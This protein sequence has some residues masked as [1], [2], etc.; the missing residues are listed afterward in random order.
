M[1]MT[2]PLSL[3]LLLLI[4][5]CGG[6]KQSTDDLIKVD[7]TAD[8]P[9]K[10]LSLQDFLDVEYIPLDTS[11]EFTTMAYIQAISD[12]A[13]IVRNRNRSSDG[14]IFVFDR[15]G[16]G[17]RKINR[18][19]PGG[20]EYTFL[21]WVTW[22]EENNEVF[23]NDHRTKKIF[24]Y[25]L[26]GKFKR[27]FPHK[28]DAWY[29]RVYNFDHDHL[30]C[31]DAFGMSDNPSQNIFLI[32]SKQDGSITTEI[33]IPYEKKRPTLVFSK[34]G[35]FIAE[36]DNEKFVPFHDEWILAETSSDTLYRLMPDRRI[37]P[38]IVRTPSIQS[39]D[40]EIFLFPGV[41][42]DRYYFMQ[43]VKK[44]Y[45]FAADTGFPGTDLV[46]DT[47]QKALFRYV[48]YNADFSTKEALNLAKGITPINKEIAFIQ[49]LEAA[50]LV[51]A[52][53]KGQLKGPLKEIAAGLNEES[54][55]VIMVAKNR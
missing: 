33:E 13:L 34:D 8:Y 25:D 15:K 20:E 43:A 1:K 7:V 32:V 31:H 36:V 51:E 26:F 22:D 9:L 38:F 6:N 14:D 18:Q 4:S 24:V 23:V 41:F 42:T 16:K 55:P 46:Y 45:D 29:D 39:M 35:N 27:S 10:E 50:D 3:M 28:E 52:Y 19:G 47:E 48:V 40:Q 44:E 21:L 54:N 2:I 30:I 12:N 17:L 5:G 37:I 11:R 49:K 53:E